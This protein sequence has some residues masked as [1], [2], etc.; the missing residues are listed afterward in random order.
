MLVSDIITMASGLS[1]IANLGTYS[2]ATA[3]AD[4]QLAWN[5]IYGFLAQNDDDCFLTTKYIEPTIVTTGDVALGSPTITNIPS[6]DKMYVTA[7]VSAGSGFIPAGAAISVIPGTTSITCG[8]SNATGNKTTDVITVK[9]FIPDT[10]QKY[11]YT[12]TLPADFLRL[13]FFQYEAGDGRYNP[14]AKAT[15]QNYT[16]TQN[17]P[18]YR[19]M[20]SVISIYDAVGYQRFRLVYYPSPTTLTTGTNLTFPK[21]FMPELMAYL[22]AAEA[23]RRQRQDP[24]IFEAKAAK[25]WATMEMQFSRDD[26]GAT[27]PKNMFDDNSSFYT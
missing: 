9:N 4:A 6:T 25:L 5:Q 14:L 15:K 27:G 10:Y 20:G 1:N 18:T 13:S 19:I 17:T 7:L 21:T 2:A 24:S 22:M 11:L 16:Q 12:W 23:I 3:L 26:F 8:T